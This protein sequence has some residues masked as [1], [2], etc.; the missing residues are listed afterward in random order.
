M[1]NYSV[2]MSV[3]HKEQPEFFRQ[4]IDSILTQS[5]KTNDFVLVCDGPLTQD[6]EEVIASLQEK[7]GPILQI[8]RLPQNEGLARAL[9]RG[10]EK[11][12]NELIARMDS[13]DIAPPERCA[14]QLEVFRNEPELVIVGGNIAEFETTPEQVVSYKTMPQT[15]EQI[16]RFAK[17]RNPFNHPTVMFRKSAVLQV[18][19]YPDYPWQEDY[20]LWAQLLL[21]GCKGCN[22]PQTL[23]Y[24]RVSSDFYDRRGGKALLRSAIRLRWDL[25]KKGL[26]GFWNFLFV[27]CALTVS[28]L[29]PRALRKGL[30][31]SA[32]RKKA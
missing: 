14:L 2:L 31:R 10:L 9:N 24:M 5:V 18:G 16:L 6:L 8:V 23:C 28:S 12:K 32:L 7:L 13:D 19:G 27:A 21:D 1:E 22:L 29:M 25:Y 30:Y 17:R 11:C 26:Y 3:Y 15:Q 20:A 4:S